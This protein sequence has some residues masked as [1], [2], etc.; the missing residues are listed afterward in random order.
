MIRRMMFAAAALL[1]AAILAKPVTARTIKS[2]VDIEVR[3]VGD[4]VALFDP[5]G[6]EIKPWIRERHLTNATDKPI[7]F[8]ITGAKYGDMDMELP[9]GS[10]W[11]NERHDGEPDPALAIRVNT[12]DGV[13]VRTEIWSDGRARTVLCVGPNWPTSA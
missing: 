12:P 11:H 13:L 4:R 7:S 8:T 1:P 10:T 5:N 3:M 9:P 6:R 2:T